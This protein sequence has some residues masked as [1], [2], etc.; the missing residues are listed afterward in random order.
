MRALSVDLADRTYPVLVGP[1]ARHEV[2]RFLPPGAKSAA[3]VTQEAI[4]AAGWV[5]DLDPGVPTE[6]FIIPDG[7]DAKTLAHGGGP[8][9]A[10]RAGR[11]LEGRRRRR[12]R[13]G[14]R[15]RRRRLRRRD[16]PPGDGLRERRH[17]AAG[18]GRRG[19]RRQ[20]GR[21]PAGGQE[22]RRRVLAAQRRPVRHRDPLDPPA[23]RVGLW[24]RRDRQVRL[25]RGGAPA[26]TSPSTSRWRAASASRRRWWP[27]TSARAA[28]A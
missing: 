24:P 19:H 26:P 25:P 2:G 14:H 23:A 10:V 11:P 1:G 16:L 5:H 7:E 13:R 15:D 4:R 28:A 12:R 21:Q 3:I 20:D 8:G 9:P 6:L 18:P 22:P 27:R 17:L